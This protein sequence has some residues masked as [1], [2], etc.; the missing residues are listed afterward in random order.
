MRL[1]V[2][3]LQVVSVASPASGL[4][5]R[6]SSL[7]LRLS[8]SEP[9]SELRVRFPGEQRYSSRAPSAAVVVQSPGDGSFRVELLAVDLAGNVQRSFTVFSWVNDTSTQLTRGGGAAALT[10]TFCSL[11]SSPLSLSF[12][13]LRRRLWFCL[14]WG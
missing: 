10:C 14:P 7:T 4:R 12:F 1:T 13:Q 11:F 9:L 8:V 6:N 3:F 5:T 2:F